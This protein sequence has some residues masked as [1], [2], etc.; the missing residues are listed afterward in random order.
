MIP[1]DHLACLRPER[2][3]KLRVFAEPKARFPRHIGRRGGIGCAMDWHL[4]IPGAEGIPQGA[5]AEARE[6]RLRAGQPA[7]VCCGEKREMGRRALTAGEVT[8]AAQALSRY[9]LASR[10]EELAQGFL[11]LPGGHRL[12]VCGVMGPEG[13]REI[14]S[15]CLRLAREIKG[16]AAEV[17][18]RVKGKST[19]I[20]GPPGAGKTTLLRDLIRRYSLDGLPV[21]VADE[22]GEIAACRD[23]AP[24]LDVGPLTDVVTGMDRGRS[25]LLLLRAMAPRV[26]AADEVGGAADVFA[27]RQAVRCGV[28]VL[29]AAHG[30]SLSDALRRP[31]L[32]QLLREGA[33]DCAVTLTG[34]G[35]A[36]QVTPLPK[37]EG[38]P[39]GDL[40]P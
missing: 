34:V 3:G 16:A 36:P 17:Y 7:A 12:G 6:I 23:G 28:T 8:R 20:L 29:S 22:R 26:L 10:Q 37:G 13:L 33:F 32:G 24:Q 15:L 30:A 21:G 2:R 35:D 14:T 4:M 40:R 11:P 5:W 18:P 9:G 31:G 27:V 19:L 38:M 1:G 25:F 39:W